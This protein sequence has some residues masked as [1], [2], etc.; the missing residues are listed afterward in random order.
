MED[1]RLRQYIYSAACAL[2]VTMFAAASRADATPASAFLVALGS[3]GAST[4][5]SV[6]SSG[7]E[8]TRIFDASGG[9]IVSFSDTSQD[10]TPVSGSVFGLSVALPLGPSEKTVAPQIFAASTSDTSVLGP[11]TFASGAGGGQT[12]GMRFDLLG[13]VEATASLQSTGASFGSGPFAAAPSQGPAVF[14]FYNFPEARPAASFGAFGASLQGA[15]LVPALAAGQQRTQVTE[16]PLSSPLISSLSARGPFWYNSYSPATQGSSLTLTIPFQLARIPVKVHLGEQSVA[17]VQSS[18]L[19]N[20]ILG[21]SFASSAGVAYSAV[22]GGVTLALPVLSRRATVSLDGLY[23]TLQ[24]RQAPFTLDP[25]GSQSSIMNAAPG[26]VIYTPTLADVQQYVGAASVAL[27][28]TSRLT[29]N[30]SF[31]EQVAGNVDLDALT[32]TLTQHTTG[33]G[34]G[35]AYAFPKHNSSIGFFSQVNVYT[36]ETIPNYNVTQSSQNLYFS[37]KF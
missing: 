28:L 2:L 9:S 18:S 34:G 12:V 27:P 30:G 22:S 14:A 21:P 17:D 1:D 24:Q 35:M 15:A 16:S 10:A 5:T 37:V 3:A 26:T 19:A 20:Q 11:L 7:V 8:I 25:Y 31:T 6:P 33:Y 36:D 13:G 29:V 32:Q 4:G 23:E